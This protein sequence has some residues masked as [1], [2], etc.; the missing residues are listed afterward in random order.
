MDSR[1]TP[2]LLQSNQTLSP[3]EIHVEF[4]NGMSWAMPHDLSDATLQEWSNGAQQVSFVWD[5]QG[6][7]QGSYQPNGEYTSISRYMIDFDTMYQ[8]NL[9]NGSIRKVKVVLVASHCRA[10]E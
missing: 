3:C 1:G 10:M 8:C 9:D 4:N 5:W 2:G 7:R 6:T